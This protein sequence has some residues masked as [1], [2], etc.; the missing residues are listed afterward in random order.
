MAECP[1]PKPNTRVRFPS[2]APEKKPMHIASVFSFC[3]VRQQIPLMLQSIRTGTGKPPLRLPLACY[4]HCPVSP[5]TARKHP[6][7]RNARVGYDFVCIPYSAF[8][9]QP[10]PQ[11]NYHGSLW[12]RHTTG[13]PYLSAAFGSF[14]RI[15]RALLPHLPLHPVHTRILRKLYRRF[16]RVI[17]CIRN[18]I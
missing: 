3:I 7:I 17:P 1:L 9:Q 16:P 8:L 4:S 11:N 10:H 15:L 18:H 6:S 5:A 13:T 12:T 2:S 14:S